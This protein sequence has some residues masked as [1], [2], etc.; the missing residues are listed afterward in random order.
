MSFVYFKLGSS[1]IVS[2][3][4]EKT[5]GVKT[6]YK[7]NFDEHV[8]TVCSKANNKLRALGRATPYI[9]VKKRRY[10]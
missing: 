3:D 7:L 4:C 9:M 6:D 1:L 5:L 2:V 10:W 8:K